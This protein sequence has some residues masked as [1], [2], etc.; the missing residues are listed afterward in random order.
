M[1]RDINKPYTASELED[2]RQ[3]FKSLPTYENGY[4]RTS[5]YK[6]LFDIIDWGFSEEKIQS[7]AN[8]SETFYDGKL[9]LEDCINYAQRAYNPSLLARAHAVNF[10]LDK[11]GYISAE[12]Y[13]GILKCLRVM[14]P[15]AP[16]ANKTYEDFVLEADVN[17]DGK[18]NID[19]CTAWLEKLAFPTL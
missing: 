13:E 6:A 10:D 18:V 5:D 9:E 7:I 1:S 14:Y 4:I 19:E 12:E 3:G 15:S 2:L 11:D 8:L 17:K 16:F